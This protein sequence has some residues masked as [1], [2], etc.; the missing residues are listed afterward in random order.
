[1][2]E[3]DQTCMVI[4]PWKSRHGRCGYDNENCVLA[5]SEA[6]TIFLITN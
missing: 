1:M 3:F 6:L 2:D 4:G 5:H